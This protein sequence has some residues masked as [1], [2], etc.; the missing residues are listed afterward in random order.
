MTIEIRELVIQARITPP[1]EP[2]RVPAMRSI[3]QE[4]S[5]E[6][7]LIERISQHILDKLREDGGVLR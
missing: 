7:R 5:E 2:D 1:T 3:A 6:A 4:K